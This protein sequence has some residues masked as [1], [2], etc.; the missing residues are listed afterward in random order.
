[1]RLKGHLRPFDRIEEARSLALTCPD[2]A[3][4][5]PTMVELAA[6]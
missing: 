1:M 3:D 2:P 5:Q 6:Q 4:A